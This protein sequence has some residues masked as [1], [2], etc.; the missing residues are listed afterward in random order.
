[1][2]RVRN[3]ELAAIRTTHPA[4]DQRPAW[5]AIAIFGTVWN[6]QIL[7]VALHVGQVLDDPAHRITLRV[8]L[9]VCLM[10]GGVMS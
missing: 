7:R 3:L 2:G 10:P 1:M 8:I 5:G 9:H 4:W 6:G